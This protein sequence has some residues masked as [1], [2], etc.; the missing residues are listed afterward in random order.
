MPTK[1]PNSGIGCETQL[2]PPSVVFLTSPKPQEYA[3]VLIHQI[4]IVIAAS[5]RVAG[6]PGFTAINRKSILVTHGHPMQRVGE[7]DAAKLAEKTALVLPGLPSISGVKNIGVIA[8]DRMRNR[9]S[10]AGGNHVDIIQAPRRG[11]S[12]PAFFHLPARADRS[13][14][15]GERSSFELL[16]VNGAAGDAANATGPQRKP[17]AMT[18]ITSLAK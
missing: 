7:R 10:F 14:A 12:L 2:S 18:S 3:G 13:L 16:G 8:S 6:L 17:A 1:L 11:K 9:P 5:D 4:D 15:S